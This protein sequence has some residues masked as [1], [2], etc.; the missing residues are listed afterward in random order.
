MD[1]CWEL[2]N[3]ANFYVSIRSGEI[4]SVHSESTGTTR[5]SRFCCILWP[6]GFKMNVRFYILVF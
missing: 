3:V 2:Y 5:L 1:L 6:E 4:M